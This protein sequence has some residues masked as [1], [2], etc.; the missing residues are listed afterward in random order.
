MDDPETGNRSYQTP[1]GNVYPSV[2]TVLKELPNPAL[3]AW[4]KRVG[5]KKAEATSKAATDRGTALHKAVEGHLLNQLR[6]KQDLFIQRLFNQVWPVLNAVDNI[7]LIEK[8]I[9]SDRMCMAG[10]PDC[11][12]EYYG[13]LSVIDF[14]TA[15][16]SKR[17]DWINGY[18]AQA[19]AYSMMYNELYGEMPQ[20]CVIIIAVE[21]EAIP[22]VFVKDSADCYKLLCQ[23][24]KKLIDYRSTQTHESQARNLVDGDSG[25][26]VRALTASEA[27]A[28]S[29]G[30]QGAGAEVGSA[31]VGEGAAPSV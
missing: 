29:S 3:D 4:R 25:D 21:N 9:Y 12:A 6:Q 16:D 1:T 22:Q 23:Y 13:V 8:S 19:G 24:A 10:T 26:D 27:A 28:A 5:R 11:I 18:Y 17:E 30:T 20:K 15:T 31:T 2:T 7:R 14:K